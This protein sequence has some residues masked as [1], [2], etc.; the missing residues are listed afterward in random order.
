[1]QKPIAFRSRVFWTDR[2]APALEIEHLLGVPSFHQD[3][4]LQIISRNGI[5]HAINPREIQ[6]IESQ[7]TQWAEE[8]GQ[9]PPAAT[10]S[11]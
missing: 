8:E 1:M 7:V 2:T 9:A 11:V 5:I 6:R 10:A 4:C 3:F